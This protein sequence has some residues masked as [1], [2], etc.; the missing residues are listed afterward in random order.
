MY[1]SSVIQVQSA[2]ANFSCLPTFRLSFA[3][4][5]QQSF[6]HQI[7]LLKSYHKAAIG[8]LFQGIDYYGVRFYMRISAFLF[9][10]LFDRELYLVTKTLALTF[11]LSL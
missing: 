10:L 5:N 7:L 9:K 8:L 2:D 4:S 1:S 3:K 11:R 6:S